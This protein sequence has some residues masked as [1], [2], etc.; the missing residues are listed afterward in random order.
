MINHQNK[1]RFA[2]SILLSVVGIASAGF[3]IKA[4]LQP[5]GLIDG[6]VTGI[7]MLIAAVTGLP[8]APLLLLLN[9]P[10]IFF[11]Y[12]YV[13][14]AFAWRSV[15]AMAGLSLF[16][17]LVDC[18]AVT[19]DKLLTA[20][21]GGIFLGAGIG[22]SIRGR[23]VLDGTE[24]LAL[25]LSRYGVVTVGDV[26][27]GLNILIFSTA[28]AFL[29]IESALYSVLTYYSASKTID[30]LLHGIEEY[31]GL[32]VVSRESKSLREMLTADLGRGV[33]RF[34]GRGGV[35]DI[36]YDILFCVVTRIELPR[37]QSSIQALDP[38]AF[39][40]VNHVSDVRGGLVKPRVL[41]T[42]IQNGSA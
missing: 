22:L 27:L 10:F 3:G 18:P 31:F 14:H 12:R 29:G 35:E 33:T 24:I 9:L 5:A 13:G 23:G 11:G 6:G 28:A 36:E 21:F 37:I 7:S 4:F 26:V 8:L 39:M 32:L 2:L 16:V 42:L 40:V 41:S 15:T 1:F 19:N 30:F 20:V 25:I 17:L 38:N 34:N